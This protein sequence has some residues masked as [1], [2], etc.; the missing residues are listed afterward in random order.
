VSGAEGLIA[1][2]CYGVDQLP[3]DMLLLPNRDDS[4]CL[5]LLSTLHLCS[6]VKAINEAGGLI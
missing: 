4:P 1:K 5:P 3:M 6:G 2:I